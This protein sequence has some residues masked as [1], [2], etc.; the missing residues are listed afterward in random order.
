M[1]C[2]NSNEKNFINNPLLWI[3]IVNQGDI[4]G[5]I[6]DHARKDARH[7]A[8]LRREGRSPTRCGRQT[9]AFSLTVAKGMVFRTRTCTK[10]E[11]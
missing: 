6:N 8:R 9:V 10:I 1:I 11:H 2:P 7:G 5:F 4:S 3:F